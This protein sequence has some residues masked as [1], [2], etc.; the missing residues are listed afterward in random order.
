MEFPT[1]GQADEDPTNSGCILDVYKNASYAK[2]GAG[3]PNYQR[4]HTWPSSYGF[5][6]DGGTNYPYSDCHGLFL[7]DGTYNS[8]RGNKPFRY[9]D[10]TCSEY[11]TQANAGAGGVG[12]GYP[13]DSNWSTGFSTFGTWEVWSDRRG[14]I[15]RA[16]LYHDIRYEGGTHGVTGA[17]EPNLILTND[18][19]LIAAS[20]TGNN[21]P[22]AY[23][24]M[25]SVLLEWHA[26]DPP[27]L[28]EQERN[29]A[30]YSFQG[31]RNPF[32]D[33]PEWGRALARRHGR[34]DGD[35][36]DQRAALRQ[37]RRRRR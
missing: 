33:H 35:A 30:I 13:G 26:Q 17:A 10:P 22:V 7:C 6:N 9:C 24:G 20:S 12:G 15:A 31:N 28:K 1:T 19:A 11:P 23:M 27:D 5:P 2:V 36:L 3:N 8:E 18:E 21:E 32:I 37:R 34:S 14:D 16:Q 4:E 25:L 29:D